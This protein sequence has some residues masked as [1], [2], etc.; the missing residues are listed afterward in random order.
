M[1][2]IFGV[3]VVSAVLVGINS[4]AGIISGYLA[5][6]I[7]VITLTYKWQKTGMF[8][9]VMG[10]SFVGF[11]FFVFLDN[12]VY[13]LGIGS[14]QIPPWQKYIVEII[15]VVSSIIVVFLC[16][17]W[18]LFGAAGSVRVYISRGKA[19]TVNNT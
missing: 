17:V 2:V 6:V 9:I 13:G 19:S 7:L 5:T 18:F 12:A 3:L 16:P 14:S 4:I 8:L 11:F 10:V 1:L 15:H